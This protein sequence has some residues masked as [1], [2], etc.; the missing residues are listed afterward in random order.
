MRA[1]ILVLLLLGMALFGNVHAAEKGDATTPGSYEESLAELIR[2]LD[3]IIG[4]ETEYW[5]PRSGDHIRYDSNG[6]PEAVEDFLWRRWRKNNG[7]RPTEEE[8][9]LVPRFSWKMDTVESIREAAENVGR[10]SEQLR[11]AV[12]ELDD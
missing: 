7:G 12:E 10:L 6:Q 4:D 2:H 3:A 9:E 5:R 1:K 8:T 11:K